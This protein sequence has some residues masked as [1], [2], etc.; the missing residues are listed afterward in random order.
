MTEGPKA[1]AGWYPQGDG[2]RKY[3]DGSAW[4]D[5][6]TEVLDETVAADAAG[7]VEGAHAAVADSSAT[8]RR[9]LW[10]I[11][12]AIA[13]VVVIGIVLL[14]VRNGSKD[15]QLST[16]AQQCAGPGSEGVTLG[17]N[18]HTL[19]IDTKGEDDSTGADLV[20]VACA[21]VILK[22]PDSVTSDIDA[23]RALDGRQQASWEN[24]T[25]AWRYHPN[26]GL[27]IIFT[28]G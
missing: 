28:E 11:L 12:G 5:S 17:D 9:P 25:A 19:T 7:S 21:A 26:S 13:V 6:P 23:T 2:S 16:V 15:T 14:L 10:V 8:S 18:G 3:W 22:M 24:Y 1:P 27:E 20:T 4:Q